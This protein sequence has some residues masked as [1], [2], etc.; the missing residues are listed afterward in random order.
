MK[1]GLFTGDEYTSARVLGAGSRVLSPGYWVLFSGDLDI[2]AVD[3]GRM[4]DDLEGLRAPG[5]LPGR[6]HDVALLD[7]DAGH[8]D[9]PA[10]DR[11]LIAE[12]DA[13]VAVDHQRDGDASRRILRLPFK[14]H[15]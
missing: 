9:V 6:E 2:H 14:A 3:R 11:G 13:G 8:D 4:A 7:V 1:M 10:A 5:P 12:D 15:L